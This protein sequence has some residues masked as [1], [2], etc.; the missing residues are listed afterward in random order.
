[1]I[2]WKDFMQL[3]LLMYYPYLK[4]IYAYKEFNFVLLFNLKSLFNL[5]KAFTHKTLG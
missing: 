4:N 1:M 5:K 2:Y 3:A